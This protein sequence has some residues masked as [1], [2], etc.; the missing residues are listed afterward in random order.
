[1]GTSEPSQYSLNRNFNHSNTP[2]IGEVETVMAL[3]FVRAMRGGAQSKMMRCSDGNYYVV[4]FLNNPQGAKILFNDLFGSRLAELMGLPVAAG[5][6][7]EVGQ[8]LIDLRMG[9]RIELR[10][11]LRRCKAGKS[12]GSQFAGS[13]RFNIPL[14]SP[15]SAYPVNNAA[16]F[17]GMMVF[18]QWTCNTDVR[19]V[20]FVREDD[21]RCRAVMID[22]GFCFNATEWNF[23][24][25]PLRGRYR[26]PISG[27]YDSVVGID[28]FQP[29]LGRVETDIGE[30]AIKAAAEG[31]PPSWYGGD[32]CG[33]A[34][35]LDRLN[36]RRGLVRGLLW[37]ARKGSQMFPNWNLARSVSA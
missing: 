20:L 27:S 30:L 12:F 34:R 4:K 25:S 16:D 23:P 2:F 6:I 11:G 3:E 33:V 26:Y 29:W 31:I 1:V 14:E 28:S 7:V 21:G 37:S 9:L 22:Q 35:L 5:R 36:R 32:E 24:D 18:D 19:Q 15:P 10:S 13:P 8:R 17:L